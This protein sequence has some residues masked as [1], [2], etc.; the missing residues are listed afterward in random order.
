MRVRALSSSS[1]SACRLSLNR[2]TLH[3]ET[4][5]AARGQK[6][7][8]VISPASATRAKSRSW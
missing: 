5:P 6:T 2:V 1:A 3:V 7:A 8:G 4:A